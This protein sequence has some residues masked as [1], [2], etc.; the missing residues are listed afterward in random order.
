MV[1]ESRQARLRLMAKL[2]P[3]GI[4]TLWCPPLTHYR[5]DGSVDRS[6]IEKHLAHMAQ[7]VK[8]VL[9]P[10]STGDGW[11]MSEPEIREVLDIALDRASAL[12]LHLLVGV[13]RTDGEAAR[14]SLLETLAWLRERT[15]AATDEDALHRARV[16]GFTVCPPRGEDLTQDQIRGA[17]GAILE[18]GAPTALYQLPQVTQNEMA[19]ETVAGLAEKFGNFCLFKDSSGEDRVALSAEA[20]GDV[21]LVRGA[22]GDYAGWLSSG[23]GPYNGLLLSTGNCFAR[24]LHAVVEDLAQGRTEAAQ[25]MS[26]RLTDAVREVFDL[27]ADLPQG[28]AFTN[29]NKAMDHFFA[30]GPDGFK[31]PPPRL[32]SG[33][34]LPAHVVQAAGHVLTRHGL[35]PDGGYLE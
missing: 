13:L 30:H 25:A 32:H 2:F 35:M 11:E 18:V 22:E 4:P 28:N 17:L 15:Q 1:S 14:N 6:R 12:G 29:A 8:G 27:V 26:S 23:G 31:A 33:P 24:E 5:T 34:C 19:P 9:V 21:F 3:E 7:W 20:L 10:G 16:C